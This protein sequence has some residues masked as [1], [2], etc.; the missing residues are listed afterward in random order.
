MDEWIPEPLVAPRTAFEE[1]DDKNLPVIAGYIF[2][3]SVLVLVT[4]TKIVQ[5]H[6]P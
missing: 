4:T 5:T 3:N 6:W 1:S 2:S